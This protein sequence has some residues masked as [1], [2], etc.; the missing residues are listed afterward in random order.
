[1]MV[2]ASGVAVSLNLN[3]EDTAAA[4]EAVYTPA[5]FDCTAA[6]LSRVY[7]RRYY[8]NQSRNTRVPDDSRLC[9]VHVELS[10]RRVRVSGRQ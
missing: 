2:C 6:S 4:A 1:M 9:V 5:Y 3:D 8:P 7:R 10:V